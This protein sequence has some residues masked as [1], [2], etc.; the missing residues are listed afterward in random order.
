M[1]MTVRNKA[2]QL[3]PETEAAKWNATIS[4]FIVCTSASPAVTFQDVSS[5]N[6]TLLNS[7]L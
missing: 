4:N 2:Q 3:D 7:L 1:V 5:E 6:V